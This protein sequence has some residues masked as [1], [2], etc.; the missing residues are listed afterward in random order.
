MEKEP[1][2]EV[3]K[4]VRIPADFYQQIEESIRFAGL[5]PDRHFSAWARI[6]FKAAVKQYEAE[7]RQLRAAEDPQ[8]YKTGRDQT[9]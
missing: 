5:D 7:K 1:K 6:A 8:G 3:T 2:D 9:P 4:A